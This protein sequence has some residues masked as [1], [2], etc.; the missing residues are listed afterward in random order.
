M[1]IDARFEAALN[2]ADRVGELRTLAQRLLKEGNGPDAVLS[3]FEQVR[4][5]LREAARDEEEDA[6]MDVMDSLTGWCSPHM[7]IGEDQ[8][9]P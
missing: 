8:R 6:V 4:Q 1:T 7:R 3:T 9:T 2:S 5:S